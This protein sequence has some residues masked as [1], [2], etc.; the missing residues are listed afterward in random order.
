M[1]ASVVLLQ[2]NLSAHTLVALA[3]VRESDFQTKEIIVVDNGSYNVEREWLLHSAGL[4]TV[5][6][7]RNLGYVQ[8]TNSG[9][10]QATG[11]VVILCN[12]DIA[13]SRQC[14]GRL[15]WAL[16]DNPKIGWVSASYQAGGWPWGVAPFPNDVVATLEQ[17]HGLLRQPMNDWA[18]ELKHKVDIVDVTEAT[19]VAVR[20]KAQQQVGY[21]WEDLTYHHNYDYA[22]RLRDKG[23]LTAVCRDAV[24]W[25]DTTHP[26]LRSVSSDGGAVLYQGLQDSTELMNLKWG[27]QWLRLKN[28]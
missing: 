11:D 17:S 9:W 2:H 19:V 24:F 4:R 12:N 8:G 18:E 22:L 3:S 7:E 16:E 27:N 26:T 23:W 20:A 1:E 13:L 28:L 25:H 6:N 15:V 10:M 21:F 14:I 5:F